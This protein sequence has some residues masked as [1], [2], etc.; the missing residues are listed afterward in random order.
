M[1]KEQTIKACYAL[2]EREAKEKGLEIIDKGTGHGFDNTFWNIKDTSEIP[3][4]VA[5]SE[6]YFIEMRSF[7]GAVE[8]DVRKKLVIGEELLIFNYDDSVKQKNNKYVRTGDFRVCEVRVDG[9]R[10]NYM[11]A[12]RDVTEMIDFVESH[13][14]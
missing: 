4:V 11:D 2:I 10:R 12:I 9:V 13:K 5:S 7:W 1:T 6:D 3:T 14:E 8:I